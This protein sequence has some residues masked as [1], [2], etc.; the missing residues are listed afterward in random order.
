MDL[1]RR[2]QQ[3]RQ[4]RGVTPQPTCPYPACEP[5]LRQKVRLG[6]EKAARCVPLVCGYALSTVHE[7]GPEAF[8]CAGLGPC[9]LRSQD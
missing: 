6:R 9:G 5:A 7:R 1:L 2:G 4:D 3:E 8:S